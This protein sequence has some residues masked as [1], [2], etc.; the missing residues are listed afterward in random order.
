[1]SHKRDRF[2][3]ILPRWNPPWRAEGAYLTKG[4]AQCIDKESSSER[5]NCVQSEQTDLHAYTMDPI[6][7]GRIWIRLAYLSLVSFRHLPVCCVAGLYPVSIYIIFPRKHISYCFLSS[8]RWAGASSLEVKYGIFRNGDEGT[9][10][11][12]LE[13]YSQC[14]IVDPYPSSMSSMPHASC[15]RKKPSRW[16]SI[17]THTHTHTHTCY[18]Y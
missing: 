13:W 5:G 17:S 11:K 6:Q 10:P 12:H 15:R 1:M 9:W 16:E 4:F 8:C 3:T 2:A 14:N 7:S 18:H